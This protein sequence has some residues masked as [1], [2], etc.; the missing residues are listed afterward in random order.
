MKI[1]ALKKRLDK[2]RPITE[3][4]LKIPSDALEDLKRVALKLG[5]TDY[6]PLIKAY[7]GQCLR[8]D[9]ELLEEDAINR[10]IEIISQAEE[11]LCKNDNIQCLRIF[12]KN[13]E[14]V[15]KEFFGRDSKN[16]ENFNK[17]G[18]ASGNP[19]LGNQLIKVYQGRTN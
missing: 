6:Q 5:F 19:L 18:Y 17:Y 14:I 11:L 8:K 9:L 10:L 3:I 16:L 7:I 4:A 2:N 15:I 12:N 1:E 13:A